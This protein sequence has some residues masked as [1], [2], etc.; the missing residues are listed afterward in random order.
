MPSELQPVQTDALRVVLVGTA[1]WFVAFLVQLPI[2]QRLVA[3]GHGWWLWT[4]LVGAGLG[5]VGIVYCRRHQSP[6][7]PD[8]QP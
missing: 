4:C 7:R 8:P 3:A 2:R 1:L 6:G 5:L